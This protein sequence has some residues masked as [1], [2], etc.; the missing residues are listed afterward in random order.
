MRRRKKPPVQPLV[1]TKDVAAKL[2]CVSSRTIGRLLAEG[3]LTDVG[4][5]DRKVLIP[6]AEI[7]AIASGNW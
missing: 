2:L 3:R 4:L 1:V 7:E 6:R 5:S